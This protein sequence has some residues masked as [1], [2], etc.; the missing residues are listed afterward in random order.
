MSKLDTSTLIIRR[1]S[2][3]TRA[4]EIRVIL[5]L[6]AKTMAAH[7]ILALAQELDNA[8]ASIDAYTVRIDDNVAAHAKAYAAAQARA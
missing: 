5:S 4:S 3:E 8:Q 7:E 2:L 1:G 6:K